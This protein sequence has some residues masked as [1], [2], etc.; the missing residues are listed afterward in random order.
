MMKVKDL[1]EKLQEIDPDLDVLG[2]YDMGF[3]S[4]DIYVDV[5]PEHYDGTGDTV[6]IIGVES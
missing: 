4:G 2:T 1:I 3:G 6:C 5:A